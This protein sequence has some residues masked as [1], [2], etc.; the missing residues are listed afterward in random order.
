MSEPTFYVFQGE[1]EL[2]LR[3]RLTDLRA[4]LGDPIIADL[5]TTTLDGKTVS[6]GQ[7]QNA[8]GSAPFLSERRLVIVENLFKTA[9]GDALLDGLLAYLPTLPDWARVIFVETPAKLPASHPLIRLANEHPRGRVVNFDPPDNLERWIMKR[10]ARYEASVEPQAAHELAERIHGDLRLADVELAKLATYVDGQR[11]IAPDDVALFTPYTAEANIF[12]MVDAFGHGDGRTAARLLH[13]LLDEGEEPLKIFGMIVRQYRLLILAR[14]H[15]D[16]GLPEHQAADT[17]GL[18]SYVA[19]KAIEQSRA[20]RLDQLERVYRF[21]LA[22]DLSI[23][24]GEVDPTLALDLLASTLT[25][26]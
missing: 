20:Y 12:Q 26:G 13:R 24:T 8:A 25:S 16:S 6:L 7:I 19:Q 5:N 22:T 17:L 21:L 1:D 3:E 2:T 18:H 11:P 4:R 9:N 15:L 23:K 10:A 14:E